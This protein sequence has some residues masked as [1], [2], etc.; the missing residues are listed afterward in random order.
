MWSPPTARDCHEFHLRNEVLLGGR[1][2][3]SYAEQFVDV[4]PAKALPVSELLRRARMIIAMELGKDL[5][6]RQVMR[7]KFKAFAQVSVPPT[8]R[9]L[10]KIDEHHPYFVRLYFSM[11]YGYLC[12]NRRLNTLLTNQWKISTQTTSFRTSW[13]LRQITSL[14]SQ[15]PC[16]TTKKV[17][18]KM[19]YLWCLFLTVSVTQS[20]PGMLSYVQFTTSSRSKAVDFET[21]NLLILFLIFQY[22]RHTSV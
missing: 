6:L 4:N 2:P 19:N 1:S 7:Q 12:Y 10:N 22:D 21:V 3:E 17:T 13:P 20:T 14:P 8:K 9:G 15:L 16:Q 18:S 5:L 11:W